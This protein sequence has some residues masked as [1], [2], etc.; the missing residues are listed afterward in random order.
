MS[1]R[2]LQIHL[3]AAQGYLELGMIEEAL[4]ELSLIDHALLE[5]PDILELRL[6][7]LIQAERWQ[8]AIAVAEQILL[9]DHEM[10]A[11]FIQGAFALHELGR[12]TEA[13][14][15]LL[16]GPLLLQKDPTFHYN[17]GCYEAV[18]GN[19]EA[20]LQSLQKS[21][22]MDASFRDFAKRDPDLH[23]LLPSL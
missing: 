8:E 2:A 6:H 17:I 5:D 19:H 16:K 20:A 11:A 10:L 4:T 9:M 14:D 23:Q 15:L 3:Q 22:A 12:T 13:R 7:I 18:L 1:E 21:F